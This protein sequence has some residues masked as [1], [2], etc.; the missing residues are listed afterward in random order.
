MKI[1]NKKKSTPNISVIVPAYNEEKLL[2]TFLKEI[3]LA[4]KKIGLSNEIILVE[5]GSNDLTLNIARKFAIKNKNLKVLHLDN[6]GYGKALVHGLR[7][8]KGQYWIIYNVDFWDK[9]F[10]D[11]TII[12]L[13]G[14]D[15]IIGSKNLPGSKDDRSFIRRLI[16]ISFNFSL[17]ILFGFQGTDTHGVKAIRST[18]AIAILKQCKTNTG[19]FDSEFVIRLQRAGLNILE[20][21]VRITEKRANRFGIKR[22]FQ[23]PGD[24]LMLYKALSIK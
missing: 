15:L 8:A 24:L 19:I 5:N 3:T 7:A 17:K 23:T 21:P 9:K 18:K 6:P 1:M 12:D 16:T 10:L 22:M 20:L 11:L 2:P 13:L 14:Y 4:L